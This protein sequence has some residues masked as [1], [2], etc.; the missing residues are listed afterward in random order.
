MREAQVHIKDGHIQERT[1]LAQLFSGLSDGEY[2]V[3]LVKHR[4]TTL[5]LSN[6]FHGIMVPE[7]YQA[8]QTGGWMGITDHKNAKMYVCSKFLQCEVMNT[9]TG[10]TE[11]Y[12]CHTDA[13][14]AD[15]WPLFIDKVKEW[16]AA[17]FN[18]SFSKPLNAK[19]LNTNR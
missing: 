18:L 11:T 3:R 9:N 17:E 4:Q 19:T 2:A 15:E 13:L 8:M 7:I 16:A 10:E 14:E 1:S 12:T 6:F 5:R